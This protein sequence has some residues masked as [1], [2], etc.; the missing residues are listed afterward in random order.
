[1]KKLFAMLFAAA[2]MSLAFVSCS[3]DKDEPAKPEPIQYLESEY[4]NESD[5]RLL[6]DINLE[7]DSSSIYVYNVKFRMGD[8][9][10]PALN[11]RVDAP[12]TVDKTGKVY[13]YSGTDI[14]PYLLRGETPVPVPGLRVNNMITVV[15]VEQKTYSISFACKGNVM[16]KEIDGQY[17]KEGKLK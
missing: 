10:S 7:K 2:V 5:T 9:E 14:I 3:D 11:I 15:N 16:G 4:E 6:F 12:C 17:N 13:T 8:V 1:M